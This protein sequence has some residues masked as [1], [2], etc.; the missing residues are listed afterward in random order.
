[1]WAGG[2]A[3]WEAGSGRRRS[4]GGTGYLARLGGSRQARVSPVVSPY[5]HH[6]GADFVAQF[7]GEHGQQHD[8]GDWRPT[9]AQCR[10]PSRPVGRLAAAE[11]CK[12]QAR[13]TP[14]AP[15]T[16]PGAPKSTTRV[17]DSLCACA[18]PPSCRAAQ[19]STISCD[20]A[21]GVTKG[22]T[23]LSRWMQA[24]VVN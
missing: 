16:A 15:G 23:A 2:G 14:N 5:G 1:M 4:S 3:A 12:E 18:N 8:G 7:Q 24:G 20:C 6:A 19:A 9:Q 10:Q 21:V 11:G 17:A 13:G 22:W